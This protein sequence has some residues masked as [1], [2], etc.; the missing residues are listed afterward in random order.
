MGEAEL[1]AEIK[2]LRDRVKLI[3][4]TGIPSPEFIKTLEEKIKALETKV[5]Q[6]RA[7]SVIDWDA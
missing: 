4:D 7:S 3:E 1:V 2:R 6:Q 5:D